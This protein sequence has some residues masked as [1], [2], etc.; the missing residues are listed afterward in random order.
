MTMRWTKVTAVL[1]ALGLFAAACG[2]DDDG[3][4]T[5]A[6]GSGSDA[7]AETEGDAT[8][9]T[10]TSIKIGGIASITAAGGAASTYAGIDKGAEAFFRRVND[11]GG[12]HG[13]R[14]DFLGVRDDGSSNDGN[15]AEV[16]KLIEQDKVFALVPATASFFAGGE[17]LVQ[18]RIPFFGWG[19]QPIYCDNDVSFSFIGCGVPPKPAPLIGWP[20]AVT[21]AFPE[22]ETYAV[23]GEDIEANKR[24]VAN[25]VK[26][27]ELL[28]LTTSYAES[29]V[30]ADIG[31]VTPFVQ[32]MMRAD[33]GE[34]PDAI[35]LL[36]RTG[37]AIA[38]AGRLKAAGYQGVIST[39]TTYDQRILQNAQAAQALEGTV[40]EFA[41]AP[42]INA[43][44]PPPGTRQ[45]LADMAKYFPDV[46]VSQPVASGYFSA[47]LF[48]EALRKTGPD[49]TREALIEA[50]N[51]DFTF[52]GDGALGAVH[53]PEDHA[54]VVE[55]G[56]ASIV[57]NGKF[58]PLLDGTVV[59]Y[60]EGRGLAEED[61]E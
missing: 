33:D 51:D 4:P 9:V 6:G 8:G 1:L 53:Y 23:I 56:A 7:P 61:E 58:E 26:G 47:W 38:L 44:D 37:A 12:V 55:C 31:D 43:E 15:T 36:T 60:E 54:K 2:D 10:D 5:S 16:L 17:L 22:I 34:P 46:L 49:L 42:F 3:E 13:R 48:V 50:A 57:R 27:A 11:E 30:A 59:C 21:R 14:I 24:G 25:F 41:F 29:P 18:R 28:G 19:T 39:P 40:A 32:E 45:F 52:D 20:L 35:F